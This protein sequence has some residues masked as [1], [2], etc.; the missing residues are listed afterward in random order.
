MS[1]AATAQPEPVVRLVDVG[2]QFAG[3]FAV[4]H[5]DLELYAGEVHALLGE[6]GAGKSTLINILGGLLA[7]DEGRILLDGEQVTLAGPAQA[8]AMGINVVHQEPALFP[9]L[10]VAENVFAGRLPRRGPARLAWGEMARRARELM[11][12]LGVDLDPQTRVRGLSIADQQLVDIAKALVSD[13]RVLVLDEPTAAL[14]SVEVERLARVIDGLRAQ[15]AAIVFIGHRLEEVQALSDRITVLRD[16]RRVVSQPA[17]GITREQM[18]RHMVGR[19]LDALFPKEDTQPGATALRLTGA[20]R[21]GAF[22]DVSFELREG[23]ILGFSGLV[24]AGRTEVARAIFGADALDAGTIEVHG[25]PV[26]I[27][28]VADAMAL[29]IAYVPEDRREHGLILEWDIATNTSLGLLRELSRRLGVIDRRRERRLAADYARRLSVRHRSL[30]QACATLSGGNQ[31]KVVVAKWLAREPRILI[32]DEPTR[33][34]DIGTKADIHRLTSELAAQGVAVI[35]ISSELPEIIG[36]SDRVLVFHEGAI[37]AELTR[38]QLDE[39]RLMTAAMGE[40]TRA[41]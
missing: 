20:T 23:E 29:G 10:T 8:M 27:R 36:M 41:D 32:L 24:G 12:T 14:T 3:A 9:D 21:A 15:G 16:G 6:N 18:I 25:R 38:A 31:Q 11:A 30:G 7:P 26:A 4:R 2:K 33:G 22:R 40:A 34:V 39:E 19:Q 13:S 5:V 17:A 1:A 35:L 28:S 37:T